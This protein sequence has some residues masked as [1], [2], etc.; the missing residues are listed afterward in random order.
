MKN[1]IALLIALVCFC[2]LHSQ[3]K[4]EQIGKV[5]FSSYT[6]NKVASKKE[7]KIATKL[8][9]LIERQ[10]QTDFPVIVLNLHYQKIHDSKNNC[11]YDNIEVAYQTYKDEFLG[12]NGNIVNYDGEHVF[13]DISV[14]KNHLKILKKILNYL[15]AN[16]ESLK[17]KEKLL[18]GKKE[19][20]KI[21]DEEM[22]SFMVLKQSLNDYKS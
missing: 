21:T 12:G 9:E 15:N 11:Y 17:A 18:R 5:I 13:I 22:D 8:N 14:K 4:V 20:H 10:K 1:S 7:K 2:N 16:L 3:I 6:F 19:S